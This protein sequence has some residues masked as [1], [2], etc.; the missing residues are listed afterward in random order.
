MNGINDAP[1][2]HS[3]MQH[4]GDHTGGC[5]ET[6]QGEFAPPFRVVQ[7]TSRKP[8]SSAPFARRSKPAPI[9]SRCS[10]PMAQRLS[11]G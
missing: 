2:G 9:P 10:S 11:F 5:L 7:P 4:I 8:T 1:D 6:T 3:T